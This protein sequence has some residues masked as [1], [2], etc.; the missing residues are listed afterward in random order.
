M[1]DMTSAK[2][3][4][5]TLLYFSLLLISI[6]SNAQSE[7]KKEILENVFQLNIDNQ[8]IDRET[9]LKFG[10][11]IGD[12]KIV[13]LGEQDHGDGSTFLVKA[14]LIKYL[15]KEKGFNVLAFET[16]IFSMNDAWEEVL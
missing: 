3:N 5:L 9:L 12:R 7:I 14:E 15:H 4:S 16:D 1:L 8:Q 11:A 10:E 2:L 6:N 13:M